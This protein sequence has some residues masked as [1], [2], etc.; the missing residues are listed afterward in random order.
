[1]VGSKSTIFNWKRSRIVLR[2]SARFRRRR[3]TL[4][5]LVRAAWRASARAAVKWATTRRTSA[6]DGCGSSCGRH[7]CQVQLIEYLLQLLGL[8]HIL[9]IPGQTIKSPVPLLHLRSVA[10]DAIR[11]EKWTNSLLVLPG[12]GIATAPHTQ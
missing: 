12:Y 9:D 1:M 7:G 4:L 2:Y 10:T 6:A 11:L 8:R 5:S 3:T